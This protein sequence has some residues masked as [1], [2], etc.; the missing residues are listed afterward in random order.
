M[1]TQLPSLEVEVFAYNEQA[2]INGEI[3]DIFEHHG[4]K[5]YMVQLCHPQFGGIEMN[6]NL[7]QV[8]YRSTLP[9]QN[10]DAV[11]RKGDVVEV[12]CQTNKDDIAESDDIVH[13]WRKA[14]ITNLRGNYAY[15]EFE[16][17]YHPDQL[18]QIYHI[19]VLRHLQ[20]QKGPN[21]D[22]FNKADVHIPFELL[23]WV[24]TFDTL[25]HHIE[26]QSFID[27]LKLIAKNTGVY[28]INL[29]PDRS[30]IVILGPQERLKSAA[31]AVEVFLNHQKQLHINTGGQAEQVNKQ[32]SQ[33]MQGQFHK[34]LLVDTGVIGLI[35]GQGGSNI[36]RVHDAFRVQIMIEKQNRDDDSNLR[37]IHIYGN[38]MQDI[39]AAIREINI[40]KVIID[41]DNEH[42]DHVCGSN[43]SNLEFMQNKSGVVTLTVEKSKDKNCYQ[44]VAVGLQHQIDDLR[45]IF[46][47]HLTYYQQVHNLK[48]QTQNQIRN[49]AVQNHQSNGHHVDASVYG[50]T[51]VGGVQNQQRKPQG[52]QYPQNYSNG[53][54][55]QTYRKK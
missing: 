10:K 37:K 49:I 21:P 7:Q 4:Q 15:L 48:Q 13:G 22:L 5:Q 25:G 53:Q 43:D 16:S 9:H 40:Q 28:G 32:L 3:K 20:E 35:I 24:Q 55:Q 14:A 19:H 8:R 47:S 17:S 31:I 42:V 1:T 54:Q 44:L 46:D 34:E 52:Q 38:S 26:Y 23:T 36:K 51:A 27:H 41:I 18:P 11:F 50:Q 2:W 39:D 6:F 12:F 33:P 30:R 45:I 29:S